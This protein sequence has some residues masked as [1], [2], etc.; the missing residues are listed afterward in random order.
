LDKSNFTSFEESLL[1]LTGV[2]SQL[3]AA[4]K[5]LTGKDRGEDED[6]QWTV[7]NHIQILLCS[8]LDEWKIFQ[9]LGK[10]TAIRDTLEITSPALRRIRSWTGLTRIRSTLLAH[11]Q[12]KI[13]GKPA[14]TWDVFNSNKSP[15]A[16][17]ETILLGQLAILVIRETLKRHYGDYH[18]AA[19]RLSQLYIPIKGQGLR[20]VG[21]ANAVLNS[22]RAEMS[23]IAERISCLN[24]EPAKKRY[25][26]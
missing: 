13:D 26:P 9:S 8:F 5:S 18:H 4:V 22:I 3:E 1:L 14:W 17:G 25:L 16:Y 6:L 21:E 23:E 7:S 15:T 12:R 10:D 24:N 2:K 19:Q 20:T 11:G